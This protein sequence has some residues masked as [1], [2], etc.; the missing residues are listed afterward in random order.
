M[1]SLDLFEAVTEINIFF[2]TLFQVKNTYLFTLGRKYVPLYYFH[3]TL[4]IDLKT[5]KE[6]AIK[7]ATK[8]K[9]YSLKKEFENYL[10]LG[11]DGNLSIQIL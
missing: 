5:G 3:F 4:G 7:F 6:V 11:A 8:D 10:Y 9:H 1:V 2:S